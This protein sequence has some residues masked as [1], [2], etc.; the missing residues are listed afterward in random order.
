[1]RCDSQ[2]VSEAEK[3]RRSTS[4]KAIEQY[5]FIIDS[6]AY[7]PPEAIKR[8]T[9]EK[10][11]DTLF[12]LTSSSTFRND[13]PSSQLDSKGLQMMNRLWTLGNASS[14][15]ATDPTAFVKWATS[16]YT[17]A[18][19]RKILRHTFSTKDQERSRQFLASV[20]KALEEEAAAG[21]ERSPSATMI[22][23][24][25]WKAGEQDAVRELKYAVMFNMNRLLEP[26]SDE[27]I[28]VHITILQAWRRCW[29]LE[30]GSPEGYRK[31]I[32]FLTNILPL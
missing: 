17:G 1:M 3:K 18:I 32:Q 9:R 4:D 14:F 16:R 30:R 15:L 28:G 7:Y 6:I 13:K 31:G 27:N 10:I 20:V 19:V 29:I 2:S 26:G 23:E 8:P 25:F 5:V 21:V 11:L 22:I 24:E 12:L